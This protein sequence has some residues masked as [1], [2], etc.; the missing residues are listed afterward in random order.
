MKFKP[1]LLAVIPLFSFAKTHG[2]FIVKDISRVY[3]GD[4]FFI[5]VDEWPSIIGDDIGIRVVGIDTPEVRSY[6]KTKAA[7]AKER[8]HGYAARDYAKILLDNAKVIE[9]RNTKRG[10]RF[11]IVAE[12]YLDDK[13]FAELMINAGYGRA[14]DGTK[15]RI[16]WCD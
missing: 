6:C 16:S 15:K 14:Y 11:R 5:N 13:N 7:K 8:T 3:D 4:T 10:S 9:L 1:L 12:V 2:N